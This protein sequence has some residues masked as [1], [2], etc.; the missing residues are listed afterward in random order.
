MI[1]RCSDPTHVQRRLTSNEEGDHVVHHHIVRHGLLGLEV[2]GVEHMVENVLPVRGVR[3]PLV[4]DL[5]GNRLHRGARLHDLG[6][7]VAEDVV[8]ERGPVAPLLALVQGR[9]H[10]LH[11]GMD[12]FRVEAVEAHARRAP[13]YLL[14]SSF[15]C[16]STPARLGGV[17]VGR[18][19]QSD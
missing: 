7:R 2:F 4:D 16:L 15:R 17:I 11:K 13:L 5:F 9:V 18:D 8:Q 1:T 19:V 12:I 14:V 6:G 10:G 3:L